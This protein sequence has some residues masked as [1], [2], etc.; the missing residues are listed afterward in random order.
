MKRSWFFRYR[1]FE[2]HL[3]MLRRKHVCLYLRRSRDRGGGQLN[4]VLFVDQG[5]GFRP[6]FHTRCRPNTRQTSPPASCLGVRRGR[7]PARLGQLIARGVGPAMRC[8]GSFFENYWRR[9]GPGSSVLGRNR[10][11]A[12]VLRTYRTVFKNFKFTIFLFIF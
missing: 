4:C 1:C 10:F 8:G 9:L 2:K 11:F 12:Q 7:R 6:T 3:R 5:P